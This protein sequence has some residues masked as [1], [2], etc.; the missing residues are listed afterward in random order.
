[1]AFGQ[2]NHAPVATIID[3]FKKGCLLRDEGYTYMDDNLSDQGLGLIRGSLRELDAIGPHS[4][5]ALIPLWN[6]PSAAIRVYAAAALVRVIPE[7]ALAVLNE[8]S[9]FCLEDA[10]MTASRLL[11]L[12]EHSDLNF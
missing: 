10:R 9:D 2:A 11:I 5:D 12:Y 4:R 6:D 3:S 7:R 8:I 1:M